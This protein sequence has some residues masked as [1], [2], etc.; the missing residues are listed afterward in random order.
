ME[1]HR[2]GRLLCALLM[3]VW[4]QPS[5][6]KCSTGVFSKSL[7]PACKERTGGHFT[8]FDFLNLITSLCAV[9]QFTL[10]L[11][12]GTSVF[13]EER[14]E[15]REGRLLIVNWTFFFFVRKL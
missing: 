2:Q 3:K 7:S 8:F 10:L 9:E 13:V 11:G 5:Y 1:G 12:K 15:S 14:E 4:V 6:L